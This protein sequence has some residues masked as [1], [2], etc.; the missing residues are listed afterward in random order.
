[1]RFFTVVI[2]VAGLF[3]TSCSVNKSGKSGGGYYGGDS[4]PSEI[5]DYNSIP[6]AVPKNEPRSK[7]GNNPYEALGKKYV[8]LKSS[9]GFVQTGAASWYGEKFHGRRT[10][11]GEIYDM[12]AMTAAHPVLPLPTYV[13]VTSLDSGKQ[14]V[15]KINDRGPFL[16]SRIIDLSYAAAHKI[17]IADKGTGK[18]KVEALDPSTNVASYIDTGVYEPQSGTAGNATG[19]SGGSYFIQVGAFSDKTNVA[20]MRDRLQSLGYTVYPV[21]IDAQFS[22]KPPFK[23][24]VGPYETNSLAMSALN[25]LESQLGQYNLILV[26]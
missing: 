4:P 25:S 22:G 2:I 13:R 15:V 3:L 14:I 24:K 1:M 12:W 11:S 8:P 19:G 10:S 17:G 9:K 7:T 6:D 21:T 26:K 16:H 5:R 20:A 18:V 23:V